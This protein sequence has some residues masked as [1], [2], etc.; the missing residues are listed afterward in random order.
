[1]YCV[2]EGLVALLAAGF[3][4][5]AF[6]MAARSALGNSSSMAMLSVPSNKTYKV[7]RCRLATLISRIGSLMVRAK[8]ANRLPRK[9]PSAILGQRLD[10][11][12]ASPGRC[13]FT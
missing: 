9:K 5:T 12:S 1:M 13:N 7:G 2:R 10:W 4:P 6:S 11:R 8:S 3:Q